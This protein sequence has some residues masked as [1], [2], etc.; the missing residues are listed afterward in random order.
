MYFNSTACIRTAGKH[1]NRII[2]VQLVTN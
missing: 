2:H 1:V